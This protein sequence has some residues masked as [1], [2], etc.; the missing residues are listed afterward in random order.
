MQTCISPNS[1]SH[2]LYAK[3]AVPMIGTAP[4]SKMFQK[5]NISI[6]NFLFFRTKAGPRSLPSALYFLHSEISPLSQPKG[7]KGAIGKPP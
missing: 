4:R 6:V 5:I 1:G 7:F 2:I 3:K